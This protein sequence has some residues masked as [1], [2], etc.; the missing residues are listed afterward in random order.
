LILFQELKDETID[1]KG[2]PTN[3]FNVSAVKNNPGIAGGVFTATRLFEELT[4]EV[5]Q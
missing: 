2:G 3:L 5:V 4:G 1:D